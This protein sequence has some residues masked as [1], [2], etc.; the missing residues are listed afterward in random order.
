M[1]RV[2]VPLDIH[3]VACNGSGA[4]ALATPV[5]VRDLVSLAVREAIGSRAPADKFAR[6]LRTTLHGL[7]AG[8]FIVDVDG[9]LF[10]DADAV[11]VCGDVADV[12]FFM[13]AARPAVPHTELA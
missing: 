12:R 2:R 9:R 1:I 4:F 10:D 3:A 7:S 8:R 11:V 6:S 5:R 13:P